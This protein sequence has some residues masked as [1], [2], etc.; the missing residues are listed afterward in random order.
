MIRKL[1][2]QVG[3]ATRGELH[4]A[5]E[6]LRAARDR[7]DAAEHR[8]ADATAAAERAQ[9]QWQ[10]EARRFKA[11]IAELEAERE[12]QAARVT[13]AAAHASRR[14]AA[15][16]EEIQKRDTRFEAEAREQT[17]LEQRVAAA[18]SEL[19]A[20]QRGLMAIEVKLDILEGAA[21]VLN[22]RLPI[23]ATRPAGS[24]QR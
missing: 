21:N 17:A 2:H 3:L 10:E 8:A 20:A 11:R 9:Q 19:E 7:L 14:I 13:E 4:V 16:E 6:K 5:G 1:L 18:T 24:S 12:R 22:T 15:L 23:A